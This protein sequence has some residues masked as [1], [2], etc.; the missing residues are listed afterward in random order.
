MQAVNEVTAWLPCLGR[1]MRRTRSET[2]SFSFSI[3]VVF[4]LHLL[5]T[6]PFTLHAL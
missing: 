3:S 2:Y 1:L 6:S 5:R 4:V